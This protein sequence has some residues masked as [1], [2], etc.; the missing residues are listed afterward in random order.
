M[1]PYVRLNGSITRHEDATISPMSPG[2][3]YG[4]GAFE[5]VRWDGAR[6]AWAATLLV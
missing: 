2:F 1:Y 6:S 5:T 3:L 4:D